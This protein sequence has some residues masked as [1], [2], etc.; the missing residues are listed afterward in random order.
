MPDIIRESL[1]HLGGKLY[2][3]VLALFTGAI[4]ALGM[5]VGVSA[6]ANAA[7]DKQ[8]TLEQWDSCAQYGE[9]CNWYSFEIPM[10]KLFGNGDNPY[11]ANADDNIHF[12][13]FN[14]NGKRVYSDSGFSNAATQRGGKY[15][16]PAYSG[17]IDLDE[18]KT[19]PKGK[20]TFRVTVRT[21]DE[22]EDCGWRWNHTYTKVFNPCADPDYAGPERGFTSYLTYSFNW[23]GKKATANRQSFTESVKKTVA[24]KTTY[25]AKKSASHTGTAQYTSKQTAKFKRGGKTYKATA[26]VTTKKTHKV[27]KTATVKVK[28]LKKSATSTAKVTSYHSAAD[29]KKMAGSKATKDAK[30]KATKAAKDAT[31]KKATSKA[32]SMITKKVKDDAK[33]KAKS[34]ITKKVKADTQKKAYNVALKAAKKKAGIK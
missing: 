1:V 18:G 11:T 27:T 31:N 29:S 22:V 13:L 2:K 32:K 21:A 20:Y 17:M 10:K 30:T 6:P 28:N 24:T 19:L 12:Q 26:S 34:K 8:L 25:T 3:K 14:A 7:P 5:L 23:N 9:Y 15:E 33:K 16:S 4:L